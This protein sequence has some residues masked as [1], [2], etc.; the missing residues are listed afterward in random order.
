[1][2]GDEQALGGNLAALYRSRDRSPDRHHR[3]SGWVRKRCEH[4]ANNTY[5][6]RPPSPPLE[7]LCRVHQLLELWVPSQT[8]QI[9]VTGG[10]IDIRESNILRAL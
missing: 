2:I 6:L 3:R 1:M 4:I 5:R 10:P 7:S 9:W 8:R